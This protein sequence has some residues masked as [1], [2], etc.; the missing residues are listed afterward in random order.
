MY[1]KS[2][3]IRG[4][5]SFADKTHLDFKE[6]ITAVVGPN[7]SGKS[8]ISD[9]VRWV[10]GEQSVKS[11]RGGKMEDIIFAGTEYRKALGFAEVTLLLD[12]SS[13]SLPV[14]FSEVSVTRKL[15]RS[16][17][18][19]YL[20]NKTTCRLRDIHELFM[21]TGIG[22]E[23]YSLI[24]QGKIE[25]ILS[26]KMEDRRALLEE[27]AG[28]VKFKSRKEEGEKKLANTDLNLLRV[29]DILTTYEE[30]LEPLRREKEK[31]EKF[32]VLSREQKEI[33]ISLIIS[34][35]EDMEIEEA[36]ISIEEKETAQ[37]FHVVSRERETTTMK[38]E[39]L[40]LAIEEKA[41]ETT[42]LREEFFIRRG[43]SDALQREKKSLAE[44][45][46]T[47]EK[48][49]E[50]NRLT[51]EGVMQRK[52]EERDCLK[53][54]TAE[55]SEREG[56]KEQLL[57]NLEEKRNVL[58]SLEEE[59]K[60]S[61]ET[62]K[63]LRDEE[64][65]TDV[66]IEQRKQESLKIYAEKADL[67]ARMDNEKS[68]MTNYEASLSINEQ[69]RA[70]VTEKLR[71]LQRDHAK[72]DA[73]RGDLNTE[74]LKLKADIDVK[75][76]MLRNL[77]EEI[78]GTESQ[79]KLLKNLETHYEGY[80][81]SVKSLME[82]LK[83]TNSR[84]QDR[85]HLV[86]EVVKPQAGFETALEIALGAGVSNI[87]TRDDR[88]A[89]ELIALL[90]EK[91][92]GRATFL[93]QNIIKGSQAKTPD[94]K[95]G[96]LLG[97]LMD[98]IEVA[99]EFRS[100][101]MNLV[102]RIFI[103]QDL[104]D[105]TAAAKEMGYSN[106]II[107]LKGDVVNAGGS[108]TGGSLNQKSSG[109]FSRKK[110]LS[111]LEESL[112]A[113]RKSREDRMLERQEALR[114]YEIKEVEV[115]NLAYAITSLDMEIVKQKER[116]EAFSTDLKRLQ[117]VIRDS[118]RLMDARE[119]EF[120]QVLLEI[121]ASE[122]KVADLMEQKQR[123]RTYLQEL[124]EKRTGD[125]REFD[126]LKETISAIM[127][128]EG[129]L[130]ESYKAKDEDR[131]R[132]E[133]LVAEF[134]EQEKVLAIEEQEIRMEIGSLKD[135]VIQ[136]EKDLL[137]TG[138]FLEEREKVVDGRSMKEIADKAALRDLANVLR[139]LDEEYHVLDKD[140]YRKREGLEKIRTER[141]A[142]ITRI[143]EE[144]D[145]TLAEAREDR[146]VIEDTDAARKRLNQLRKE[147]SALGSVNVAAIEEY[148]EVSE[149]REFLSSQKEDLEHAK[150]ELK[151][152][153]MEMTLR[154]RT[155][156]TENFRI[157]SE[158]FEDTF[159]RLF[160]GGQ[161]KL[162]L[163]EGDVLE[164]PIEI[165]VQPPGK[166]LQNITLMSG[167]EKVLSAIALTFA[168][169]RMKPTPFCILDEIEAALDEANVARF[170]AFLKEFARE[171][172][173]IL[174]THRKGTMESADVLYGVTMEEK[175][176]SKI[177]SVDLSAERRK[178]EIG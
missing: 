123:S 23:G 26:G 94:L 143:N 13:K 120:E 125:Y 107:T 168:I 8:N 100:I 19:E 42:R 50:K 62:Q 134:I 106:R 161:A 3:E 69:A 78:R 56:E 33:M 51:L 165:S 44:G 38:K 90:R 128:S 39:G 124:K 95:K 155:M 98:F 83:A 67:A 77:S 176:I 80:N 122:K 41:Q 145:M 21:D 70:A 34:D 121:A 63:G 148:R 163:G 114:V 87:I 85:T 118:G 99:E 14:P 16:G 1:L 29:N 37:R 79:V 113:L 140:L 131:L 164:A 11:L 10:L 162:L 92:L 177:V 139:T 36:K 116:F 4:F 159:R 97:N 12:N 110:D 49:L 117:D 130:L 105:A 32:L 115:R 146:I 48:A 132:R 53:L 40:E 150:N 31:A 147:I 68:M 167:G 64:E 45:I 7:G 28:I 172:Q 144:L 27:A 74:A 173:F 54:L 152:L 170:A 138:T 6:G 96:R 158:N 171:T 46:I 66:K 57:K 174:I 25:A 103:A 175:G 166:K 135:R 20:I 75:D 52:R 81:R 109:I 142:L 141:S 111:D 129:R 104:E 30:R 24:G 126:A 88:Q 15:F 136:V 58:K 22:K 149:H 5:K 43:D 178:R 157:L 72:L 59:L 156:F 47:Q 35:L 153:I 71:E 18:S 169:L 127:V 93:P 60:R 61:E 151:E 9:A 55:L 160:S 2:I 119:A 133:A 137:E 89:K 91:N 84:H 73:Q 108:M 17:E 76:R 154:M 65:E 82:H 102:G 101:A 86:G 112:T